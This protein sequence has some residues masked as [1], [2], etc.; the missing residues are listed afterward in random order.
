MRTSGESAGRNRSATGHRR[1]AVVAVLV[2]LVVAACASPTSQTPPGPGPLTPTG[3]ATLTEVKRS[4]FGQL[5]QGD[6]DRIAQGAQQPLAEFTV[7]DS[8]PSIFVNW[9]IPDGN[10]AAFSTAAGLP[11]GFSLAKVQIL[12]S[13]PAAHY[14]LSLN[15]YRVSGLTTGLRAEWSTYVDP[16][17]G[18]PR[19]MIIRARAAEGSLDPIGPLAPAEPF[20]HSLDPDGTIRTAMN[21]TVLQNGLPVL[22]GD[23]LFTSEVKL[24]EPANRHLVVPSRQWVAANDFIY[25]RNGVND[26]VFHDS[27]SH[28]APLISVD[29]GDV[30]LTDDTEWAP[31]V[32]PTPGHVLAYLDKIRFVISPWWNVTETDGHVD[33]GTL[34]S[35]GELKRS[36]Y[37]GLASATAFG[38]LFG[39]GEPL[40]RS[41]VESSPPAVHYH[42]LI[43]DDR[44]DAFRTA[45]GLP[46]GLD[47]AAVRLQQ[48][49]ATA[50][51]WLSLDVHRQS[52]DGAGMRADWTT[53]VSDGTGIRTLVLESHSSE[54]SLDPVDLFTQPS[55]VAHSLNSGTV[56]TAVGTAPSGF[57]ATFAV[58]PAA[59]QSTVAP[60]RQWVASGDLR[61]W[62]NG[63]A[64][65]TAYDSTVLDDRTSIDPAT[66]SVTYGGQWSTFLADGPDRIWLDRSG[67]DVVVDPW[68]NLNRL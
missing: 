65:R 33:P 8:P 44:L 32:D 45:V 1:S 37:S 63:V 35:L 57:S 14:W 15:V 55:P 21:K 61:Y 2:A 10:A 50:A 17:D 43:P 16:G 4:H 22:T 9:V 18:I 19:F 68:W 24:P 34:A 56:D 30:R 36:L 48:D 47:L 62:R 42:W 13:D 60:S 27:S 23:N 52:G 31:F 20:V 40:V 28:S 51:H 59:S 7:E 46:P 58:P 41:T 54:G 3:R 66:A 25:W 5:A 67:V 38:V 6:V 12:E 26:R 11:P 53:Y 49:D 64:D 29:L 39:T